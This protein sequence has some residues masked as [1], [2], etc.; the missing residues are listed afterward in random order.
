MQRETY[1]DEIC[2]LTEQKNISRSSVLKKLSP[3]IHDGLLTIGGHL[4]NVSLDQHEKNLIIVPKN[5][6][7]TTLLVKHYYQEVR[8]QGRQFTE[9]AIRTAGFWIVNGKRL[10]SSILYHCVTCRKLRGRFV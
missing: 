4:R 3:Q 2:A 5:N 7:V 8:H 10:I 9:G 1:R 6:H